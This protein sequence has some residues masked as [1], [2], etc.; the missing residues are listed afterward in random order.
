VDFVPV[1]FAEVGGA[2]V[3]VGVIEGVAAADSDSDSPVVAWDLIA[4][5]P[6]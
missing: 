1:A 5:H 2:A 4:L 3:A 6:T